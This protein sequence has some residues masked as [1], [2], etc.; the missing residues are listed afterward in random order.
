MDHRNETTVPQLNF[1]S[2]V[3]QRKTR[4]QAHRVYRAL[5]VDC[6]LPML[7]CQL[8]PPINGSSQSN[9][10]DT[11]KALKHSKVGNMPSPTLIS[12]LLLLLLSSP[13]SLSYIMLYIIPL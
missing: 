8:L 2:L 4:K 10:I 12:I 1:R 13:P 7:S 5:V 9:A 11:G 6:H 3:R